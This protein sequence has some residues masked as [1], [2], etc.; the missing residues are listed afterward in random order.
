M[1]VERSA[2]PRAKVCGEFVSPAA[3]GLLEALVPAAALTRAG[4]RRVERFVL[5]EGGREHEL[6]M[7]APAWALSRAALDVLLADAARDAGAAVE[8]P[9]LVSGVSYR[10][11]VVETRLGDG[12]VLRSAVVAHADGRGRHD[13]GG[14]TPHARGLVGIKCH[15]EAPAGVRG[16][17]IR[18]ATAVCPG[19]RGGAYV[20]TIAVEG[21]LATCAMVAQT[22]LVS[23]FGGDHDRLTRA[24]WPGFDPAWRRG[25][26]LACGVARSAYI[27]P[28]HERSF[29]VGNAAAAVDPIGGEGIGL[30][31]W[32]GARLARALLDSGLGSTRPDLPAAQRAMRRAYAAR[33]LTRRPACRLAAEALLRPGLVALARPLLASPGLLL[34]PWY[35]LSG[36]AG[37]P[38]AD[39]GPGP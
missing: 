15:F 2:F 11:G 4:A 9:A 24:L 7:S 19:G 28:G 8:Q 36:K 13:P 34:G 17:R 29:R 33:L 18:S 16:V 14:T 23:A 38:A 3:S 6:R 22:P 21:G 12:R 1:M 30:A 31:L 10:H 26:W 32:S 27:A 20:G 37:V 5:E 39:A 25:P 35:R